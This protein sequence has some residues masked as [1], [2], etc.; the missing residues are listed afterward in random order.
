MVS[1][2]LYLWAKK[3]NNVETAAIANI[4]RSDFNRA[5][6]NDKVNKAVA[7]YEAAGGK[8]LAFADVTPED[9]TSLN[10]LANDFRKNISDLHS[11]TSLR[12]AAGE[13]V[14]EM[15]NTALKV[16]KEQLDK[17][18]IKFSVTDPEF[19]SGYRSARV[20]LNRK[21]TRKEEEPQQAV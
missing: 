15:I 19:Y 16:L 5:R 14:E 13:S 18:M 1:A 9:I 6:D 8:D 17:F 20:I 12:A 3:N 21:G 7:I 4:R 11:G 10:T 2:A